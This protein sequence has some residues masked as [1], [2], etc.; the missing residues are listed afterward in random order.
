MKRISK[1]KQLVLLLSASVICTSADALVGSTWKVMIIKN[2]LGHEVKLSSFE[3]L[4]GTYI[5]AKLDNGVV[6]NNNWNF[7]ELNSSS[8]I[9][10]PAWSAIDSKT[11]GQNL[12]FTVAGMDTAQLRNT[13]YN[14]LVYVAQTDQEERYGSMIIT[15]SKVQDGSTNFY[16]GYNGWAVGIQGRDFMFFF[17]SVYSLNSNKEDFNGIRRNGDIALLH[18]I[19]YNYNDSNDTGTAYHEVSIVKDVCANQLSIDRYLNCFKDTNN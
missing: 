13:G 12:N 7:R 9:T 11:L 2:D 6:V 18:E 8:E 1:F 3:A 19:L 10:I 15:P 17:S 14:T 4:R 5:L 16:Y